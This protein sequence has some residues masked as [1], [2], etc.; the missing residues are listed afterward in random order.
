[1]LSNQLVERIDG[2]RSKELE[3]FTRK[4]YS[5]RQK[6]RPGDEEGNGKRKGGYFKNEKYSS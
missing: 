5:Y 2:N 1:M 4:L 3:K 6:D